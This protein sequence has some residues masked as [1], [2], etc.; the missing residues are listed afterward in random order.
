MANL[1]ELRCPSSQRGRGARGEGEHALSISAQGCESLIQ[2]SVRRS[3]SRSC[4]PPHPQPRVG[5]R[6][7]DCMIG[8]R[9]DEARQGVAIVLKPAIVWLPSATGLDECS[10]WRSCSSSFCFLFPRSPLVCQVINKFAHLL[11]DLIARVRIILAWGRNIVPVCYL[12]ADA[13]SWRQ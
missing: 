11:F 10:F 5:A 13:S 9:S 3:D 1:N 2:C 6:I 12:G 8:V 4:N 7:A